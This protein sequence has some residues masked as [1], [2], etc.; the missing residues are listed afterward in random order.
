[1]EGS[2]KCIVSGGE[3]AIDPNDGRLRCE[4]CGCRL[5]IKPT[6]GIGASTVKR[7]HEILRGAS[8]NAREQ[9]NHERIAIGKAEILSEA[10]VVH[11][12]LLGVHGLSPFQALTGRTPKLLS[13]FVE[14]FPCYFVSG[15]E[16]VIH[17]TPDHANPTSSIE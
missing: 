1:M 10:A 6:G 17:M 12:V 7:H 3:G 9:M 13:D 11:N 2:P 16:Q 4:R 8:P 14:D 15:E 5:K